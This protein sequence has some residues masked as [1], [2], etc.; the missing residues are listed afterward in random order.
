MTNEQRAGELALTKRIVIFL[1]LFITLCCVFCS[2]RQTD[3]REMKSYLNTHS[4]ENVL[5]VK[6]QIDAEQKTAKYIIVMQKQNSDMGLDRIESFR[7]VINDYMKIN[8][9]SCLNQGYQ[10]FVCL[11]NG[12]H[13][14]TSKEPSFFAYF[15]NF[16]NGVLSYYGDDIV[17]QETSNELN[18]IIF[19]FDPG[20]ER[21]LSV[22]GNIENI[23]FA[24]IYITD[25]SEYMNK[26][27]SEINKL[28]NL[29][30]ITVNQSWYPAFAEA[31]LRCEVK[32]S[33]SDYSYFGQI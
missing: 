25:D 20:D 9:N 21:S 16:E 3:S 18:T 23:V 30:T 14:G 15:A 29:K 6:M 26:L 8:G 11:Q 10:V 33:I 32:E 4:E 1:V 13:F 7:E 24:G 17:E 5:E 22:L 31:D 2:C 12:S 27:F 19:R 28:P